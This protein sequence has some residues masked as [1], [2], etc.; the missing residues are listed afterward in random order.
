MRLIP[1]WNPEFFFPIFQEFTN[2]LALFNVEKLKFYN[3]AKV[4][5]VGLY[6]AKKGSVVG[7]IILV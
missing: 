2:I 4:C 7:L 1:T 3:S 5:E 6:M